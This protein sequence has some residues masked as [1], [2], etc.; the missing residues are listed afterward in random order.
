MVAVAGAAHPAEAQVTVHTTDSAPP[1]EGSQPVLDEVGDS[2][3][4]SPRSVRGA[5]R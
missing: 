5:L 1:Q 4:Q 3:E 2:D